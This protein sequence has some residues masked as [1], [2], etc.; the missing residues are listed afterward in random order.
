MQIALATRLHSVHCFVTQLVPWFWA[1]VMVPGNPDHGW[2]YFLLGVRA[3]PISSTRMWYIWIRH[4]FSEL[5]KGL[6]LS[7]SF[8]FPVKTNQ[9]NK[10]TLTCP[11]NP[12]R[13]QGKPKG[14]IQSICLQNPGNEC[15][16]KDGDGSGPSLEDNEVWLILFFAGPL[17][18]IFVEIEREGGGGHQHAAAFWK[19]IDR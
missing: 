15:P 18:E 1:M 4:E 13:K 7:M 2:P 16:R 10:H 6:F 17:L 8:R 11:K 5:L 9:T 3:M 12:E 14:Q 19:Q